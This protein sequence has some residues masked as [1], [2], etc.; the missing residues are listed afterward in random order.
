MDL[1]HFRND[2]ET[3]EMVK[4]KCLVILNDITWMG[5][6]TFAQNTTVETAIEYARQGLDGGLE[7][8]F[9]LQPVDTNFH[10]WM[11]FAQLCTIL[12][13]RGRVNQRYTILRKCY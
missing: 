2:D 12:Y 13:N 1:E 7:G 10:S 4:E 3:A 9:Q 11:Q 5:Q 8:T 6:I